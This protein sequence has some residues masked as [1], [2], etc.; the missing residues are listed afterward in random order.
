MIPFFSECDKMHDKVDV[1]L[2]LFNVVL[3]KLLK[4]AAR[5]YEYVEELL[6]NARQIFAG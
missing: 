1:S 5:V 2:S 3:K 6:K 4:T